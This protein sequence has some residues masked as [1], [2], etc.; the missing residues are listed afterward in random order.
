[1][2]PGR[3]ILIIWVL[4][5]LLFTLAVLRQPPRGRKRAHVS[6]G[7]DGPLRLLVIGATGGTGRQLVEQALQQG[8]E[9]TAFVRDPARFSLQHAKLR[10]VRGRRARSHFS[11][12][13]DAGTGRS[14]L[15]ART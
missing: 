4:Y 12:A 13:G 3:L 5:A 1:M 10:V 8:H 14:P 15:R 2:P 11:R 6:L 9:V 7:K